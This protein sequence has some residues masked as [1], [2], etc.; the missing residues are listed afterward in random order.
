[1]T[2][3]WLT[4]ARNGAEH[5]SAPKAWARGQIELL[6]LIEQLG[7]ALELCVAAMDI[8]SQGM[9]PSYGRE[10]VDAYRAGPEG[11]TTT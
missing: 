3:E 9:A 7:S 1:M 8:V 4:E 5:P 6:D 2:P 10:A 11:R